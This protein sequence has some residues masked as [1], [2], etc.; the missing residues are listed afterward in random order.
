[1][2]HILR[3][4][5][6]LFSATLVALTVPADAARRARVKLVAFSQ[7]VHM[8]Y[9]KWSSGAT[10]LGFEMRRGKSTALRI[11]DV[12]TGKTRRVAEADPKLGTLAPG[13]GDL[14][15]SRGSVSHE[16]AWAPVGTKY[17]FSSNGTGSV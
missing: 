1:M 8:Q 10:H 17:L 9:P 16:L 6:V 2:K 12:A 11:Y 13:L 4:A 7:H 15:P 5:L 3:F 14:A